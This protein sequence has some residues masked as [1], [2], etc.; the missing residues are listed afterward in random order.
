MITSPR[1]N[2][3]DV[4]ILTARTNP[5]LPFSSRTQ[6]LDDICNTSPAT[7][8]EE[9]TRS[10]MFIKIYQHCLSLVARWLVKS[11]FVIVNLIHQ[12][13]FLLQ[14]KLVVLSTSTQYSYVIIL[15]SVTD[16]VHRT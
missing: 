1:R 12:I 9:V 14:R 13:G 15:T 6:K 7:D 3:S 16:R 4:V 5:S 2:R 11:Y 8:R 10:E